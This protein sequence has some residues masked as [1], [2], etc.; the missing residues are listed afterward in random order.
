MVSDH[1]LV[2]GRVTLKLWMT[3]RGQERARQLDS[4]KLKNDEVKTAFRLELRYRFSTLEEEQEI[5]NFNQAIRETK[6]HLK[7]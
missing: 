1:N 7:M 6:Q 2:T 4:K 3:K 5:N